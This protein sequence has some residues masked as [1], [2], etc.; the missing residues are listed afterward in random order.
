MPLGIQGG[1]VFFF[2]GPCLILFYLGG[3]AR[4]FFY[5]KF[6]NKNESR[7][8]TSY[9]SKKE[10]LPLGIT[11]VTPEDGLVDEV[12]ADWLTFLLCQMY[13]EHGITKNRDRLLAD[14]AVGNCKIWFA[15]KEGRPIGSAALIK[16]SDGSV[17]VGRASVAS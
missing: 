15:L 3:Q 12:Q 17:E 7:I 16:Q 9:Q 4:A 14:I 13:V 5:Y 1:T 11:I 6:I 2:E 8:R 10:E